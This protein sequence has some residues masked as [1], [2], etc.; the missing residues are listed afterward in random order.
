MAKNLILGANNTP[1]LPLKFTFLHF[2]FLKL[3]T[4][5]VCQIHQNFIL[6]QI[7]GDNNLVGKK[8]VVTPQMNLP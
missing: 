4:C 5:K 2:L 7:K 3:Q 6:H 1:H 8:F